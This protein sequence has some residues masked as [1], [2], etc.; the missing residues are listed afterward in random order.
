MPARRGGR[1]AGSVR[2]A[3]NW[4]RV[5]YHPVAAEL[6]SVRKRVAVP[7]GSGRGRRIGGPVCVNRRRRWGQIVLLAG[8]PAQ[9][10][11][12]IER[13]QRDQKHYEPRPDRGPAIWLQG[14]HQR[15]R[16]LCYHGRESTPVAPDP[17][18]GC[19]CRRGRSMN[20]SQYL[21]DSGYEARRA[22]RDVETGNCYRQPESSRTR[23]AR[24]DEMHAITL[25]HH[26]LV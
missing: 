6:N 4:G 17:A 1:A 18:I 12:I 9:P 21:D 7:L 15:I 11:Q 24:I 23:A 10:V 25:G 5:C 2:I 26:R 3:V 19:H 8:L 20:R 13:G 22:C 16:G 14:R